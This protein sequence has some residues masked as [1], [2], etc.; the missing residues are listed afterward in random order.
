VVVDPLAI[1]VTAAG[2]DA[3]TVEATAT[4]VQMTA[5]M[6]AMPHLTQWPVV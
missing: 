3:A 5:A 1:E 2:A 6:E 4:P